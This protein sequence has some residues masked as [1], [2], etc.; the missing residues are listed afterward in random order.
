M[1]RLASLMLLTLVVNFA[2]A[3]DGN[4]PTGIERMKALS[5]L[6]GSWL[7]EGGN[8]VTYKWI[9]NKS[10]IEMID[11]DYREI[12]GW[13][14]SEEKYVSWGFGTHGGHGKHIWR[15]EDQNTWTRTCD[16]LNRWGQALP[17]E[18]KM[19]LKGDELSFTMKYGKDAP[20]TTKSKRVKP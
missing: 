9:N 20:R 12:T 8:V 14:F 13:D 10:Y 3:Q 6:V 4:T 15:Q 17:I 5:G 18:T 19:V 11:G 16:W 2:T 1:R 7:G